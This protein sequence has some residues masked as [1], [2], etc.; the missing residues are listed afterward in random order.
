VTVTGTAARERAT[1]DEQ[2]EGMTVPAIGYGTMGRRG[3]VCRVMVEAALAEG[4]R[5]IDTARRYGNERE[6]GDGLRRSSVARDAVLL[7]TKLTELELEPTQIRKAVNESLNALRTDYVDLLLIHWPSPTVPLADSLATLVALR[8]EGKVRRIGVSNFPARMLADAAELAPIAT[9]QVEYHPYLAQETV[10]T[11]C[12][13]T[14]TLLPAYCPLARARDLLRDPV[15]TRIARDCGHSVAQVV[16][17]W[18]VQQPGVTA[19]PGTSSL[20]HLRENIAVYGMALDPT[21][22]AAIDA[23]HRGYRVVNPPKAPPW[24]S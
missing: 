1:V 9:N 5:Y 2:I 12:R 23:L 3:E 22:V 15:L 17:R 4:Y 11:M 14:G 7:A 18:L 19:I 8:D 24:D 20:D 21:N 6:V 16:L 10:L 13:Q